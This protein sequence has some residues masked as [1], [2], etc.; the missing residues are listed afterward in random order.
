VGAL[1]FMLLLAFCLQSKKIRPIRKSNKSQFKQVR[2]IDRAPAMQRS[3]SLA[4]LG[5]VLYF[6][7]NE[8]RW[9]EA[10]SGGRIRWGEDDLCESDHRSLG[11]G[12]AGAQ[13]Q[14]QLLG[15]R[16]CSPR[17][18]TSGKAILLPPQFNG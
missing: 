6:W 13:L 2:M 4:A 5:T 7:A 3:A 1:S 14:L 10:L 16:F 17:N 15:R 11:I 8:F 12:T 9:L 18:L